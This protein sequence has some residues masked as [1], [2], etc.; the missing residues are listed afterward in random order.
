MSDNMATSCVD[1]RIYISKFYINKLIHIMWVLMFYSCTQS[2]AP[3][4]T[5]SWV[6]IVHNPESPVFIH[7]I[8]PSHPWSTTPC[9]T[10]PVHHCAPVDPTSATLHIRVGQ[11]YTIF[12]F[13]PANKNFRSKYPRNQ[14]EKKSAKNI[15][16][17]SPLGRPTFCYTANIKK[18]LRIFKMYIPTYQST[19]N[20]TLISKMYTFL[21]LSRIFNELL[22][23]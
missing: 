1:Y 20:F 10:R 8:L 13:Q 14:P 16:V 4:G 22:H 11:K 21:P 6:N 2:T 12:E 15:D 17:W 7:T 3:R 9:H 19:Q 23:F 18:I 5:V